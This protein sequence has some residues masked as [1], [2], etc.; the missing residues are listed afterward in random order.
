MGRSA[1]P[2]TSTIFRLTVIKRDVSTYIEVYLRF[3]T[4]RLV[5]L[6]CILAMHA[7]FCWSGGM[8]V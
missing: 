7:S 5:K 2:D 3:K 1:V 8:D 6:R 4:S